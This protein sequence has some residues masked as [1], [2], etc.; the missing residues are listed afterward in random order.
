MKAKFYLI[1]GAVLCLQG[2]THTAR[3]EEP[4]AQPNLTTAAELRGELRD[5]S[6]AAIVGARVEVNGRDGALHRTFKSDANGAFLLRQ[7]PV[8]RYRIEATAAG[9]APA[10]A[11]VELT[12]G[13]E[14]QLRLS[15]RVATVRVE[16]RVEATTPPPAAGNRLT[17]HEAAA[18]RNVGQ[19]LREQTGFGLRE[20]G[21]F[22]GVPFLNGLGDERV[23]VLVDG[24][25]VSSICPNHMEPPLDSIAPGRVAAVTVIAG[26][27]PVSL[28][29]DSLG[30]TVA[31]ETR[32]PTFAKSGEQLHTEVRAG[33]FAASDG[34]MAGGSFTAGIASQ[35]L[36]LGYDGSWRRNED[37][38]D[39]AGHRLSSTYAATGEQAVTV[40]AADAHNLLELGAALHH[41]PYEGFINAQMDLT[42]D[43]ASSARLHYRHSFDYALLDARLSWRQS[44]HAMNVGHDKARM[45]EA[46]IMP[47]QTHGREIGY[48]L[49]Y[50]AQL[51]AIHTL[52][53]GNELERFRLDDR[54]PA[55]SAT[56]TM[57]GPDTF[58]D[59]S[60]GHRLRLG[61][62]VELISRWRPEWTTLIGVR[63][64]T[65]W[66]N[67]GPVAGYN[68]MMY[69]A[70][71]TAFNARHRARSEANVDLTVAVRYEDR[72]RFGVEFGY[73]RKNRAPN[74]YERYAWSTNLMA[75]AMIGWFGD[76]NAY[77]GNPALRSEHAHSFSAT[78]SL[79]P[80]DRWQWQL[81]PFVT[82]IEDAIDVD[83]LRTRTSGAYAY[84]QLRF[85]NHTARLYGG[86]LAA[87]G[88]LWRQG[89]E[90]LSLSGHGKWVNGTRTDAHTPLY[91]I[92]PLKLRLG[93]DNEWKGLTLGAA[94]TAVDRKARVD[95]K[96]LEP[97]THGYAL[98][99]LKAGYRRGP[100][101]AGLTAD[102][103]FN[104]LYAEPL[105][106]VN[107]DDEMAAG[108]TSAIKPVNGA[109]RSVGFHLTAQ[110]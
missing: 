109:G 67:A 1:L 33:G 62:Y 16:A 11:D 53:L 96:R 23:N 27:T 17:P 89:A 31:V 8:G 78:A 42:G 79:H 14:Q 44:R 49:K 60:D 5:P 52:R 20:S 18:A 97:V 68:A 32:T 75:S 65:V 47:M 28:G 55:V 66:T 100:I 103:L 36:A 71:A 21:S 91:Q 93:L 35:H 102:N 43:V 38:H 61:S 83:L 26:L 46:M 57:M 34:A 106:G 77:A 15:L 88:L 69:G 4:I 108:W 104:R 73:A 22:A 99:N 98:V 58:V 41:T 51:A 92:E 45:A 12:G 72:P 87:S 84:T 39:G 30:G 74:L 101:E 86:D 19:L 29:G 13:H 3:A 48:A 85:A 59:I 82:L 95:R 50:E 76:G 107:I 56:V 25:R 80:G 90:K 54:W 24:Q 37:R 64:D 81:T 40:A 7:L 2:Q 9:F 63:N 10:G 70:E 94:L 105:G 110:F 6:G